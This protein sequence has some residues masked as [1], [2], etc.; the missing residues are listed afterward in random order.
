M[1][2]SSIWSEEERAF[3][4]TFC[5]DYVNTGSDKKSF[6]TLVWGQYLRKFPVMPTEVEILANGGDVL[7]AFKSAACAQR[8]AKRLGQ[9]TNWLQ[10]NAARIAALLIPGLA[11]PVRVRTL[12]LSNKG[13]RKPQLPHAWQRLFYDDPKVKAEFNEVWQEALAAGWSKKKQA[14]F[15]NKWS[16]DKYMESSAETKALV[17][18]YREK[19]YLKDDAQRYIDVDAEDDD[20]MIHAKQVQEYLDNLPHTLRR[21]AE[22]LHKQTGW[23][24]S[25]T[26]G[27]PLPRANGEVNTLHLSIGKCKQGL[28]FSSWN[29]DHKTDIA[30]FRQFCNETW[31]QDECLV[32]SLNRSQS[33]ASTNPAP[34]SSTNCDSDTSMIDPELMDMKLLTDGLSL[35]G[36]SPEFLASAAAS[37]AEQPL[38]SSTGNPVPSKKRRKAQAIATNHKKAKTLRD[39]SLLEEAETFALS[40][41]SLPS[42]SSSVP[43]VASPESA[44]PVVPQAAVPPVASPGSAP[45]VVPQAAVPPVAPQAVVLPVVPP[46]SAPPVVPQAA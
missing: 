3:L 44:P 28:E 46:E 8:R 20:D 33:A 27:G 25:I 1:S 10:N 29:S 15:R 26:C 12:D 40:G 21:V 42:A 41:L 22:S 43:P 24:F 35:D 13:K 14:A 11:A 31:S 37:L 39:A 23:H 17:D 7:K 36:I 9:A 4:S 34:T 18:E 19:G 45:P 32:M 16:V 6:Y 38:D 5:V 30:N 2:R